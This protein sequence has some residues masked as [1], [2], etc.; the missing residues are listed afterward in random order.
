MKRLVVLGGGESGVGAAL[1]GKEKE[2]NVFLSDTGKIAKTYKDVL[3][4]NEIEWEEGAHTTSKIL[5][6]DLVVKSPGIPDHIPLIQ[7]LQKPLF[8]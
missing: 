4:H 7:K 1:L 6:A 3:R 8:L 5:N 2:Y